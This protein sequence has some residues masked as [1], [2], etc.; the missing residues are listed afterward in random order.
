MGSWL[1]PL[2]HSE[3][4][5]LVHWTC[6]AQGWSSWRC[7]MGGSLEAGAVSTGQVAGREGGLTEPLGT[8]GGGCVGG[9]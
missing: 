3:G 9:V 4:V 1:G 7:G 5:G 8:A 6:T 2:L